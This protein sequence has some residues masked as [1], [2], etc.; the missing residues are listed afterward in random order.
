MPRPA[1]QA[2]SAP[3]HFK[4]KIANGG[5]RGVARAHDAERDRGDIFSAQ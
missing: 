5:D 3:A 2:L 4:M 1:R